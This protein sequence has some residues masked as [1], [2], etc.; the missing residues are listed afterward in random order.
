MPFNDMIRALNRAQNEV[1]VATMQICKVNE[2]FIISLNQSQLLSGQRSDGSTITPLY[3][4]V[5]MRIK[6]VSSPTPNLRDKGDFYKGMQLIFN[7]VG[8]AE[9]TIT[10]TDFKTLG[11]KAKYG[12]NIFGL[13]DQNIQKLINLIEPHLIDW[14]RKKVLL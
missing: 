8:S 13:T 2:D 9:F 12:D 14:F 6:K 5:T 10:S 7:L 3:K 1:D 4:A 11:L